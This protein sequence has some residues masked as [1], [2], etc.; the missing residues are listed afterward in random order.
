MS[1]EFWDDFAREALVATP[2]DG[3]RIGISGT[4][5]LQ[6]VADHLAKAF[7]R[8]G[9]MRVSQSPANQDSST[10]SGGISIVFGTGVLEPASRARFHWTLWVET[11]SERRR[12]RN[13]GTSEAAQHY[14]DIDEPKSAASAIVDIH[15]PIRPVRD[16]NDACS[17]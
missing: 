9:V 2:T 13:A 3:G 10:L 15:D 16:W 6:V 1:T 14:R 11:T 12:D 4:A 7:R 5:S 8:I 17:V